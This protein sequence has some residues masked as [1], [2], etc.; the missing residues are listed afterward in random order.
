MR[1]NVS[2]EREV[3]HAHLLARE[4]PMNVRKF[5]NVRKDITYPGISPILHLRFSG[6]PCSPSGAPRAPYALVNYPCAMGFYKRL[7][8]RQE[9]LCS[10]LKMS[11]E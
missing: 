1:K 11:I 3:I 5:D 9:Y 2:S 10:T 8:K 6:G 7:E 4:A